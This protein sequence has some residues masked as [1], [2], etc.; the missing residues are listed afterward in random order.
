MCLYLNFPKTTSEVQ[1]VTSFV[2]SIEN[3]YSRSA[4]HMKG[5]EMN[6]VPSLFYFNYEAEK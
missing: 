6:Y 2:I 3:N 1:L 4:V 5:S